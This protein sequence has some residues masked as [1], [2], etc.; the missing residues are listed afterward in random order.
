MGDKVAVT[1][2][3]GDG[4]SGVLVEVGIAV[5]VET[6]FATGAHETKTIAIS[7]TVTIFLFFIDYLIMQGTAQRFASQSAAL[8]RGRRSSPARKMKRRR[9][10]LEIAAHPSGSPQRQAHALLDPV[11]IYQTRRVQYQALC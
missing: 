8:G 5:S 7:K 9:K 6:T 3:V 11:T 1:V 4:G 2:I 10:L